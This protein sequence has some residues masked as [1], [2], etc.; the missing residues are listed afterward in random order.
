MADNIL[1][2]LIPKKDFEKD[3]NSLA[4][5]LLQNITRHLNGSEVKS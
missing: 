4:D 1:Q 5:L 3:N 2:F